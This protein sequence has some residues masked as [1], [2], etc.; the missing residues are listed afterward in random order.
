MVKCPGG[1]G[2]RNCL[3]Y[4][5]LGVLR[6][7]RVR[8]EVHFKGIFGE[9]RVYCCDNSWGCLYADLSNYSVKAGS[10]LLYHGL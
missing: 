9:Y 10:Y 3:L 4:A 7:M 1:M 2:S 5:F 6:R 8:S